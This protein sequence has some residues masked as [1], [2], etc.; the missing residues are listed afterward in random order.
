MSSRQ[1]QRQQERALS[2]RG[3]AALASGLPTTPQKDDIVAVAFLL[4]RTLLDRDEPSRASRAAASIHALNEASTRRTPGAAKLACARGCSYCCHTW[5][6]AT[7]PEIFL[8][9]AAVREADTQRPGLIDGVQA[10]CRDTA[11]LSV[12]QRFGAKLPCPLLVDNACSQY[13]V[14]PAVCRQATSFDLQGCLEEFAGRGH[15]EEIKVSAVYAAHARN[16]RVPLTAA[17]RLA[18]LDASTYEFSAGLGRALE[19]ANCEAHWLLGEDVFAGIVRAP[20]DP[21]AE[22][23]IQAI[24]RELGGLVRAAKV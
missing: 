23:A 10:R 12:L 21:L 9:A 19:F 22:Q 8:A 18:G 4:A 1:Q 20:A 2:K 5:V 11:G 7:A 15:G 16:A 17:L 24:E 14:R 6:S 3:Q 13:R